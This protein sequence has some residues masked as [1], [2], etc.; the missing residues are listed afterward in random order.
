MR[1][2]QKSDH[3][4]QDDRR[5]F[6]KACGRFAAVTPPVVTTLLSTS[7]STKAIAA[8]G[9][10]G[11]GGGGGGRGTGG[12]PTATMG[13]W[14]LPGTAIPNSHGRLQTQLTSEQMADPTQAWRSQVVVPTETLQARR[15]V[16]ARPVEEDSP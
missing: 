3:V 10:S 8:S 16:T 1:E 5:S 2:V 11:G 12:D 13:G 15:G 9:G 7:L 6:L 4:E 14:T